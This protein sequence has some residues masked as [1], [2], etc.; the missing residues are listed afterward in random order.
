[1]LGFTCL[2]VLQAALQARP[3]GRLARALYPRLF[4]GF[5]LDELFTRLTFRIW[6]LPNAAAQPQYVDQTLEA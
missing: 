6:P 2:F 5:Y 4:A 3:Q 1:M